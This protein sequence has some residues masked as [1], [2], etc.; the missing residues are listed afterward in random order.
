MVT[1]TTDDFD[2]HAWMLVPVNSLEANESGDDWLV[3]VRMLHGM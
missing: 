1:L 3:Q 2:T